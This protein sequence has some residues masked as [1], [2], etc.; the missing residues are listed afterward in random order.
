ME[1][2]HND[3]KINKH[4]SPPHVR[5]K[6]NWKLDILVLL[7]ISVIVDPGPK[8]TEEGST[9][10]FPVLR[11]V[12]RE[13]C[14][15]KVTSF[16]SRGF[17]GDIRGLNAKPSAH[18]LRY[19]SLYDLLCNEDLESLAAVVRGGWSFSGDCT[20]FQY[21]SKR[22][23]HIKAVK[24]GAGFRD[25][26]EKVY[27]PS[28]LAAIDGI[29]D[30]GY[31]RRFHSLAD[32]LMGNL[33]LS[34]GESS[35]LFSMKYILLG[36]L[37]EMYTAILT[38]VKKWKNDVTYKDVL[39]KTIIA[40]LFKHG[41]DLNDLKSWWR[42]MKGI[43]NANMPRYDLTKR[44]KLNLALNRMDK[45]QVQLDCMEKKIDESN[46]LKLQLLA[47]NKQLSMM[48][49]KL[50]HSSTPGGVSI[51][52]CTTATSM[53]HTQQDVTSPNHSNKST[54]TSSA[55]QPGTSVSSVSFVSHE[56]QEVNSPLQQS[57]AVHQ[58]HP[59]RIVPSPLSINKPKKCS[60]GA[61]IR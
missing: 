9:M 31:I 44:E 45:M 18:D 57:C 33:P 14:S 13:Q 55:K 19:G 27:S 43:Q 11:K 1:S 52:C 2:G 53:L 41:F 25:I 8:D 35:Q 22:H 42:M 61:P 60:S 6:D 20:A 24:A 3:P 4:T 28:F 17:H 5:N 39:E 49:Q 37:F 36:A 48:V 7:G 21:F 32:D 50:N 15:A 54:P 46:K 47:L 38:D 58:N 34:T 40:K 26:E 59:S 12:K 10:F 56:E 30:A 29:E 51:S 16:L 23:F